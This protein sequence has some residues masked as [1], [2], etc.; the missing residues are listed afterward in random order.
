MESWDRMTILLGLVTFGIC[1]FT[2]LTLSCIESIKATKDH[3][4]KDRY[5]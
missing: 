3:I 4:N 5:P 2:I 1:L